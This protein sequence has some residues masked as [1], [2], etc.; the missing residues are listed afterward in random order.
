MRVGPQ[1]DRDGLSRNSDLH[2]QAR[3]VPCMLHRALEL[4]F[5]GV[6]VRRRSVSLPKGCKAIR[7]SL[8]QHARYLVLIF[9]CIR[10]RSTFACDFTMRAINA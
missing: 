5:D 2:D 6:A 4:T 8:H 10:S 3:G 1:L 9:S 7:A